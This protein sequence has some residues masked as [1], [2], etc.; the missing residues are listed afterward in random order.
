MNFVSTLDIVGGNSGS[1]VVNQS[2]ELVGLVFDGNIQSLPAYFVYDAA[3]NRTISVD[4]R[5]I[6]AA[7]SRTVY[8]AG[9]SPTRS[10]VR[11]CRR[12]A[13]RG[14][15]SK[16][17]TVRSLKERLDAG[18]GAGDHLCVRAGQA[19]DTASGEAAAAASKA[20]DRRRHASRGA[21]RRPR[22]E[23][24]RHDGIPAN[25]IRTGDV[26]ARL[27]FM[28]YTLDE[29]WMPDEAAADVLVQRRAG[30][31][32]GLAAPRRARSAAREDAA[33]RRHARRRP[34]SWWTTTRP[35]SIAPTSSSSIPWAPATAAPAKPE[36]G[37]KFWA[38]EGDIQSVGEFI[39]L[40]LTRYRR[41]AS[42]LFLVGESY[43]TTRAAGLAGHLIDRGIAFNGIV[44]VSSI[45]NFQTAEF[46]K[47]N[48]LP[49]RAVP[50][51]LHGDRLVPQ[52]A[53]ARPAAEGAEGDA[54]RGGGIRGRTIRRSAGARRPAA[55]RPAA[56]DRARRSRA[57]PG[58]SASTSSRAICASRS[59]ASARSCCGRDGRTVGRLD[60]RFTGFDEL[61]VTSEPEFDPSLAAIRPPYTAMFQQYVRG[62]L[63]FSSDEPYHILGGG[64][65]PWNWNRD[66]GFV[67]TSEALRRAFAQNPHMRVF[68]ASGYFDL[69]TPYFATEYTLSHL[70]L[71]PALA[72]RVSTGEYDAGHMMYIDVGEL[73]K[74]R[75]DVVDLHRPIARE[76]RSP[77]A[78][79]RSGRKELRCQHPMTSCSWPRRAQPGS[80]CRDAAAGIRASPKS[81][82]SAPD[83]YEDLLG[84]LH[85]D[86]VFAA[87]DLERQEELVRT[88]QIALPEHLQKLVDELVD[89][90]AAQVWLQQEG[91]FH[92]GVAIGLRLAKLTPPAP[93]EDEDDDD[94]LP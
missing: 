67:D 73:A 56:G 44:L 57:S 8:D 15:A 79:R 60:S 16:E 49:Y 25:Q 35:G 52:A 2:G 3:R 85:E 38:L 36:L 14:L 63:G 88:V 1:P 84:L 91:A 51:D 42:P 39:R 55:G 59:S 77:C 37:T 86:D 31:V 62:E 43:G 48:D 5:A 53:R 4:S 82:S 7:H 46:N 70:G 26:E 32:V 12:L 11:Q 40:Y 64:F 41:W 94:E 34:T 18:R 87:A 83:E 10:S 9:G 45:L 21:R 27:F 72:D 65:T 61:G 23:I 50:A 69:A 54:E 30:L 58:L 6:L 81:R 68:V 47:G 19:A 20:D 66:N 92:L 33:G 22:A 93:D 24:H 76:E 75:R 90:Q 80:R 28:A 29:R 78:R 89:N 71:H 13:E 74:L 17:S